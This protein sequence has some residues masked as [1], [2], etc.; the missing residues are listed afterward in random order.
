MCG[1]W[2]TD[3]HMKRFPFKNERKTPQGMRQAHGARPCAAVFFHPDFPESSRFPT[4]GSGIGPDLLTF[5]SWNPHGIRNDVEALAGSCE[6]RLR[7][8][9]RTYRR[10]GIAPRPE[11]VTC[12]G[13]RRAGQRILASGPGRPAGWSVPPM[14][15]ARQP[16]RRRCRNSGQ[17][18]VRVSSGSPH[19]AA[20]DGPC[21]ATGSSPV[22]AVQRATADMLDR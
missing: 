8:R 22:A 17:R 4:V 10:W 19:A 7:Q 15:P 14:T 20:S 6:R 13:C 9:H 16:L 2:Q 12:C 11:D 3:L 21:R 5:A 1:L 18:I